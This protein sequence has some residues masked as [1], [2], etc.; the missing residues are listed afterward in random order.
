MLSCYYSRQI[1][2]TWRCYIIINITVII[3]FVNFYGLYPIQLGKILTDYYM[4]QI[5]PDL[6]LKIFL[7]EDDGDSDSVG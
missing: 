5:F 2:T 3:T 1:Q 6:F 4:T 7:K